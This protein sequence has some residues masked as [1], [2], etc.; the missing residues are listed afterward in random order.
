M[1]AYN[2]RLR[3]IYNKLILLCEQLYRTTFKTKQVPIEIPLDY[4][5]TD[6]DEE[7][8]VAYWREDL[9]VNLHHWHWHLIYPFEG[10]MRIVNKDRRGEL[11]YYTHQQMIGRYFIYCILITSNLCTIYNILDTI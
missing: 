5:A 9:G 11:F 7:H 8:R 1:L 10:D 3:C 4:T 6:L 2:L